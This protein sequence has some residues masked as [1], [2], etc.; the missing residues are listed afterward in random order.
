M[1][2]IFVTEFSEFGENVWEILHCASD[3]AYIN[4]PRDGSGYVTGCTSYYFSAE[5]VS[6][7]K[8]I[9]TVCN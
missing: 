3:G 4:L 6:D 8:S 2:N 7:Q 1:T 9:E 5:N